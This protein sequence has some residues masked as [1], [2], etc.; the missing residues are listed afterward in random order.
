L[1]R[2]TFRSLAAIQIVAIGV[3]LPSEAPVATSAQGRSVSRSCSY[4]IGHARGSGSINVMSVLPT[5]GQPPTALAPA[6]IVELGYDVAF[7]QRNKEYKN[8][9]GVGPINYIVCD[10]R[11]DPTQT[12]DALGPLGKQNVAAVLGVLGPADSQVAEAVAER[13]K[14]PFVDPIGGVATLS[15]GQ[16]TW[17]SEPRLTDE[18]T[19]M[20]EY[21]ARTV[22]PSPPRVAIL[23]QSAL[24]TG[25][26]SDVHV[27]QDYYRSEAKSVTASLISGGL[28]HLQVRSY[29]FGPGQPNQSLKDQF[30][31][32]VES[33]KSFHPQVVVL[34]GTPILLIGFLQV[35]S[36]P[37]YNYTPPH[38]RFVLGYPASDLLFFVAAGAKSYKSVVISHC[39][40]TPRNGFVKT[41]KAALSLYGKGQLRDEWGYREYSVY[42][43]FNAQILL[44]A[45]DLANAAGGVTPA[46]VQ[47]ALNSGFKGYRGTPSFCAPL[48][49]TARHRY[50][51]KGFRIFGVKVANGQPTGFFKIL[52]HKGWLHP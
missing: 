17:Q 19:V 6:Q 11:Y 1:G 30:G 41:Y 35:A 34:I 28:R 27:V 48:S 26:P 7:R 46:N 39:D 22:R 47:H 2:H 51:P 23:Y 10:D 15:G 8:L 37:P 24:S 4:P 49:W 36:S 5:G 29:S 52:P 38:G 25:V 32:Q 14:V 13:Q 16:W 33:I 9:G 44:R 45:L 40:V 42:A 50:G 43:Y 12:E 31:P 3:L 21:I 18:G 20:G